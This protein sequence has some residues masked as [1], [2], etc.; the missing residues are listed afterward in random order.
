MCRPDGA[1][2]SGSGSYLEIALNKRLAFIDALIPGW[3]LALEPC[4]Q[5]STR[6]PLRRVIYRHGADR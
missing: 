6:K 2:Q 1:K 4:E 3:R 5:P